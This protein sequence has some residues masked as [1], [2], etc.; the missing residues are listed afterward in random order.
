MGEKDS[1][2]IQEYKRRGLKEREDYPLST[3]VLREYDSHIEDVLNLRDYIDVILRRKWIVISCFVISIVTVTIFSLVKTPVYKA[4][5]TIEIAPE[6]PKI[7]TFQE[8]VEV[9]AM[10]REFYETQYKLIKSRS[11]AEE[12]VNSLGLGSHSEFATGKDPKKGFLPFLKN[13]VAGVK[14][15]VAGI[16]TVKKESDQGEI[17]KKKLAR[18]QGLINSFLERVK[19]TPDRKSRL[20]D[21]SF[22]S[23]DPKL[24]AKTVNTLLDKYIEWVLDRRI[25]ATKAARAFLEKQLE[26]LKAKLERAEEELSAFAKNADIVSLDQNLNLT[27]K[28]LAELNETLSE[29]E[30]ERLS[31]EALY[32]EVQNGNYE[33]LPQVM[34]DPSIQTLKEEYTKLNSKYDNLAVIYGPNYPEIKQFNA[35]L[36]RI[37]SDIAL[38]TNAIAES[39]KK[40]YQGA[41]RKENIIKKRTA[42]QKNRTAQLNDKAIQYKI[43]ER[44][45]DT[46]QSIYENILQRLKETEVTSAIRAT[47]IQVVDYASVPLAPYK[48]NIKFNVLL[49][50][51]MGLMIGV[52]LAFIFEHFDNTIKDEEEIKR[53]YSLPFLGSVPLI[54]TNEIQ[55]LEKLAHKNPKSLISEAFRVIRTSILYSSTDNNPRSLMVTS[56]QPLEGKSTCASNLAISLTQSGYKVVLVDAD[57]RRPR[58][59][60][61]FLDNGNAFGLSTY[62]VGKMG[63]PGVIHH[64]DINRM[65]IIPTGQLPPNPAELLGSKKMKELIEHLNEEYDCVL[66]DSPPI[67]GFA[68]SRL[69][70]RSVDG[71][72]LVTSVGITQRQLLQSTIENIVNVGG[73]I[74]GTIVN[75]LDLRGRKYGYS[76]YYYDGDEKQKHKKRKLPVLRS[77]R[78]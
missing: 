22:E 72:L 35:Q 14:N 73:K 12:V 44:E 6:N 3:E 16:F 69:I 77:P 18:Q 2:E 42:E 7:T 37:R 27:Y 52:F 47:N 28:Q 39:I 30:S 10:Q 38:Q 76:Y 17:E 63:L 5:A 8:V 46:N 13:A 49:A 71:V 33:Y 67:T 11:L 64:T 9:D 74:V 53:N 59:H 51:L 43:F 66:I 65:D 23:T 54:D 50:T 36:A 31:K 68:D 25:D 55:D 62:L 56:S 21:V 34:S 70:A 78:S 32:K 4:E 60:K 1:R 40:D 24:T 75:R 58:L 26:Q 48:P 29:A 15:A 20:L 57:F 19:V 61:I 45:V 41:V